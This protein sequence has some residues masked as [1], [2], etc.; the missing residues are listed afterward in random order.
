MRRIVVT[1][2]IGAG[3][4]YAV[5]TQC[6][7]SFIYYILFILLI[8]D[9]SKRKEDLLLAFTILGPLLWV[10]ETCWEDV[11]AS[12]QSGDEIMVNVFITAIGMRVGWEAFRF[13]LPHHYLSR[14]AFLENARGWEQNRL[15]NMIQIESFLSLFPQAITQA[16]CIMLREDPLGSWKQ[17]AMLL[18]C[19]LMYAHMS[20]S[21]DSSGDFRGERGYKRHI[22]VKSIM[23]LMEFSQRVCALAL[24]LASSIWFVALLIVGAEFVLGLA[25]W[26]H[27]Q[28]KRIQELTCPNLLSSGMNL[29]GI[30]EMNPWG[31]DESATAAFFGPTKSKQR[32]MGAKKFRSA[33][34][35]VM[36]RVAVNIMMTIV[37]AKNNGKSYA[38]GNSATTVLEWVVLLS[39][40]IY[41]LM[42]ICHY[43]L[44]RALNHMLDG[45]AADIMDELE[46]DNSLSQTVGHVQI[47]VIRARDLM[48][49]AHGVPDPYCSVNLGIDQERTEPLSNTLNPV[50][51]E[52]L[53][54]YVQMR[55]LLDSDDLSL[56]KRMWI[57]YGRLTLHHEGSV[58]KLEKNNSS[59]GT[60]Y[61]ERYFVLSIESLTY[62]KTKDSYLQQSQRGL[63]ASWAIRNIT[64]ENRTP[65]GVDMSEE[66]FH[67]TIS[68]LEDCGVMECVVECA[69]ERD[70]WVRLIQEYKEFAG[71][72][73]EQSMLHSLVNHA[74][75][76]SFKQ[77]QKSTST[78]PQSLV[79]FEVKDADFGSSDNS[80]GICRVPM[81]YIMKLSP[82]DEVWLTLENPR[83]PQALQQG[84]ILVR[85]QLVIWDHVKE[86][87]Q[88]A[89][90]KRMRMA[91]VCENIVKRWKSTLLSAP[92]A[93]WYDN[94]QSKKRLVQA[95]QTILY[96]WNKLTMSVP[97]FTW[98]DRVREAKVLGKV[99]TVQDVVEERAERRRELSNMTP[100]QLALERARSLVS[101]N[102]A[103]GVDVQEVRHSEDDTSSPIEVYTLP[104]DNGAIEGELHAASL[105]LQ[106][107]PLSLGHNQLDSTD[108]DSGL[109][110][111][112]A[113]G[114]ADDLHALQEFSRRTEDLG[115]KECYNAGTDT[116]LTSCKT[117]KKI[118]SEEASDE[119][120]ELDDDGE[121]NFEDEDSYSNTSIYSK[122]IDDELNEA[123]LQL[124]NLRSS[125]TG[126]M[127]R[128]FGS[129]TPPAEFGYPA[130]FS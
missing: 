22:A 66:G 63:N 13:V 81:D 24:L 100:T 103:A 109:D 41:L 25:N 97:F 107:L 20:A 7:L 71:E 70:K 128:N 56:S 117:K 110:D 54:V 32:F 15:F 112:I 51:E 104:I 11:Y 12:D 42:L 80:I 37:Y 95:A 85:M 98:Y 31:D 111:P 55:H 113:N 18:L 59:F 124:H 99:K 72:K 48:D 101:E 1:A 45:I 6:I 88:N 27:L 92:Y 68:N 102:M 38:L 74:A 79:V 123:S 105:Q 106:S 62:Y 84:Q 60:I 16:C 127:I 64:V 115:R 78:E 40:P 9:Y 58:K 116:L 53:I 30:W 34:A 2:D 44:W 122:E 4:N 93:A 96:H 121:E 26:T 46:R 119:Q 82:D 94:V 86:Y 114:I 120:I 3:K 14:F 21:Q 19:C 87:W 28:W 50:W 126:I 10:L 129:R 89:S 17:I 29:V 69:A 75:M 36:I 130:P 23:R 57:D 125:L 43:I 39:V 73:K 52:E 49:R 108:E 47:T 76:L 5:A 90:Q 77:R 67:F 65:K 118:W 33:F 83:I 8:L 61:K 35:A 91:G